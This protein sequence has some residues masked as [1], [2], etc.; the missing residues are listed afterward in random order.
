M[1]LIGMA[2]AW[3]AW[4]MFRQRTDG[5]WDC[6]GALGRRRYALAALRVDLSARRAAPV[7]VAGWSVSG[8][9]DVAYLG[10]PECDAVGYDRDG[11]ECDTCDGEG[12]LEVRL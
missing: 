10:C 6:V 12:I 3:V 4:T 2:Y 5:T 1:T 9:P 8:W 7:V 11:N